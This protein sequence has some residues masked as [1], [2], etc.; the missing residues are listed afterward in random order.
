MEK[1]T[2][3]LHI[4]Q[5]VD[6]FCIMK[7]AHV[8]L[9]LMGKGQC[10]SGRFWWVSIEGSFSCEQNVSQG[11]HTFCHSSSFW[12]LLPLICILLSLR[13]AK[14]EGR[15]SFWCVSSDIQQF[16]PLLMTKTLRTTMG[17]CDNSWQLCALKL[18]ASPHHTG[19]LERRLWWF[20]SVSEV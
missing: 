5:G 19:L 15:V 2:I 6:S 8:E 12:I 17:R 3:Y 16:G 11:S 13:C 10:G 20:S 7:V 9:L 4:P 1:E 14:K 18:P